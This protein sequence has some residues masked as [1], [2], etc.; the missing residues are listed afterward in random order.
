MTNVEWKSG[1]RV[2][3]IGSDLEMKVVGA[4]SVGSIICEWY[5]GE[6]LLQGYFTPMGLI[7]AENA[8]STEGIS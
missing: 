6:G 1:T 2:R 8:V 7:L 4:D 5:R 3:F